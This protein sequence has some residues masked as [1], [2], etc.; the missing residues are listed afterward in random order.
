MYLVFAGYHYY[1]SGG[2]SDYQGSYSSEK[3]ALQAIANL[4]Y[5]WWQIVCGE[6]IINQGHKK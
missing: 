1:P 3:E 2:W 4:S 5:D 6:E